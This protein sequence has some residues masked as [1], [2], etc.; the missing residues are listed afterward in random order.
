MDID[1]PT[2]VPKWLFFSNLGQSLSQKVGFSSFFYSI[3]EDGFLDKM[4][5]LSNKK[6]TFVFVYGILTVVLSQ[7]C[8]NIV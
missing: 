4:L 7:F 3:L 6:F 1:G 8:P 5:A 2:F